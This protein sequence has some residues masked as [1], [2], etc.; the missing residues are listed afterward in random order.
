MRHAGRCEQIAL[1][2]LI[3][4]CMTLSVNKYDNYILLEVIR[5]IFVEVYLMWGQWFGVNFIIE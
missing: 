1:N 4:H 5:M 2:S 3:L